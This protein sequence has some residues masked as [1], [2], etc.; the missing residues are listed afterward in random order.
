[1]AIA[2]AGGDPARVAARFQVSMRRYASIVHLADFSLGPYRRDLPAARRRE[3][4]RL[5][6]RFAGRVFATYHGDFVGQRLEI[7]GSRPLGPR[8]TLVTTRIIYDGSRQP[9]EVEWRIL[10]TG[11]RMRV[12]D[13]K[14]RGIWLTLQMRSAFVSILKQN[15]GDMDALFTYL[16]Q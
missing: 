12:F 14:V 10:R 4:H 1:M 3:F 8:D 15:R 5:V 11:G 7:V 13:M 6:E 9:S 2:R 16:R